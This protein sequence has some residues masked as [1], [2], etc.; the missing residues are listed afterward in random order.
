MVVVDTNVFTAS[1]RIGSSLAARYAPHLHRRALT[2][3]YQT[4][5]EAE[6]GALRAGWGEG[7]LAAMERLLGRATVMPVDDRTARV[8]ARLRLDCLRAGHPLHQA[9]HTADLWIAATAVRWNIPLVAHDG[10]FIGCPGL[11]LITE[12]NG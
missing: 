6:Y 12:L 10:V 9:Q 11:D 4:Q 8:T 3:A 1:L 5:V 7:R 2:I